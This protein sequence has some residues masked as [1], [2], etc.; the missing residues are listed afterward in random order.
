MG[1]KNLEQI[2]QYLLKRLDYKVFPQEKRGYF[3]SYRAA[4]KNKS[5]FVY[6]THSFSKKNLKD[7]K[8]KQTLNYCK[9]KNSTLI[10]CANKVDPRLFGYISH[11]SDLETGLLE[12][13]PWRIILSEEVKRIYTEYVKKMS[14]SY[15]DNLLEK[16]RKP[17]F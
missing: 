17:F 1:T 12:N 13:S 8:F 7:Y 3:L 11:Y 16:L 14:P 5:I 2:S 4:K 9:E 15:A 10:I 6:L